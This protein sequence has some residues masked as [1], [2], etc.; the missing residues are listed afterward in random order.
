[1][2]FFQLVRYSNCAALPAAIL[3]SIVVTISSDLPIC[4]DVSTHLS[5]RAIALVDERF[6]RYFYQRN[7]AAD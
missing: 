4:L 5:V 2:R 7:S 6:P 1:M 3:L